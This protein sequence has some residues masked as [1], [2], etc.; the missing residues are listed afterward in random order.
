MKRNARQKRK[1]TLRAEGC[2]EAMQIEEERISAVQKTEDLG[3]R[4]GKKGT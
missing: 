2:V 1:K 4:E 3:D